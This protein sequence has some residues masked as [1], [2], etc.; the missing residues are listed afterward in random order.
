MTSSGLGGRDSLQIPEPCN[1]AVDNGWMKSLVTNNQRDE[2][3]GSDSK[4][5]NNFAMDPMV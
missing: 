5:R 2:T 4:S 3:F 1:M